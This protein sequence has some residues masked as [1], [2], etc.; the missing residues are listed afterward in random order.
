MHVYF[1]GGYAGIGLTSGLSIVL[2]LK[3][4]AKAAFVCRT[5]G[6]AQDC[7]R[8][9]A[10]SAAARAR[11]SSA[12]EVGSGTS[13]SVRLPMRVS[14]R[15]GGKELQLWPSTL[16]K[17]ETPS[18]CALS[19]HLLTPLQ[20]METKIGLL[21]RCRMRRSQ[22]QLVFEDGKVDSFRTSQLINPHPRSKATCQLGG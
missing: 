15:S 17:S 9:R 14:E 16:Q 1:C 20:W 4:A 19:S 8:R 7:R 11:P 22:S 13:V 3:K 12:S 18:P 2:D 10:F 5:T 6:E 21:G